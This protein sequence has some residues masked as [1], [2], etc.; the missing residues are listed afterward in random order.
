MCKSAKLNNHALLEQFRILVYAS[1]TPL[2]RM[3]QRLQKESLQKYLFYIISANQ[4]QVNMNK[5][6]EVSK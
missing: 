4:L 6:L 1:R 5:M 2:F 3:N